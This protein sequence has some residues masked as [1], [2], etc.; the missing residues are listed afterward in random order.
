MEQ[1]NQ[2]QFNQQQVVSQT[3]SPTNGLVIAGFVLAFLMP[4][5]GLILSIVGLS[6]TKKR[7]QKGGGLAV[8]GI[9]ISSIGTL[10]WLVIVPI[11]VFTSLTGTQKEARDIEREIDI[12][13]IQSQLE[14]YYNQMGQY[15]TLS[16]LNDPSWVASN[17]TG[18]ED[19]ALKDPQSTS[20]LIAPNP[21][22][23][24]YAYAVEPSNCD[25]IITSCIKYTLTATLDSGTVFSKSSLY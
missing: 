7:N 2:Q 19:E 4:L 16:N 10:V 23:S 18:L 21:V 13:A 25:N 3:E 24:G 22:K 14:I 1:F 17:L 12:R 6:Q 9:V 5:I 8:A 15:P 20:T 11:L